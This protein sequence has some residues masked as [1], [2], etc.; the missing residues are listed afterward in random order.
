VFAVAPREFRDEELWVPLGLVSRDYAVLVTSTRSGTARG[1]R[2][3]SVPVEHTFAS[4]SSPP[5]AL[6]VCGG[7]GAPRYLWDDPSLGRLVRLTAAAG[8]ILAA[9]CYG[10]VVLARQGVLRGRQATVYPAP[11]ARLELVRG[12]ARLS[13]CDVVVDGG[14]VTAGG[15][16][17]SEEFARA[18]LRALA[19]AGA[20]Q[21]PSRV[22][23]GK[24]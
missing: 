21:C 8:G 2:G 22:G 6:V 1:S 14:V 17:A 13:D 16:E 3:T 18:L 7:Q 19:V 4:I 15:P 24:P 12:G 10:V 23:A 5:R 9:S 20:S 11:R